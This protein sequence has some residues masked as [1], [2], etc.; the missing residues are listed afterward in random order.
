MGIFIRELPDYTSDIV[1]SS[2][3][4]VGTEGSDDA[5]RIDASEISTL[6]NIG[7]SSFSALKY[8]RTSE[9]YVTG[10]SWLPIAFNEKEFDIGDEWNTGT[11][12][13]EGQPGLY[14]VCLSVIWDNA[15][16]PAGSYS[17][18]RIYKP[19]EPIFTDRE[20]FIP[21]TTF[22]GRFTQVFTSIISVSTYLQPQ[23][24]QARGDTTT[25]LPLVGTFLSISR[26]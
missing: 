7:S 5:Y 25:I 4:A 13:F 21:T 20:A 26:L 8:G 19:E 17:E 3:L 15:I 22:S 12:K 24:R 16:W 11:Y 18:L 2:K 10:A 9:Y 23:V 1:A 14:R 6:D